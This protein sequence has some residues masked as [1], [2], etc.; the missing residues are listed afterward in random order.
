MAKIKII[1][2]SAS[3]ILLSE[4]KEWDIEVL[5]FT[6]VIDGTEYRSGIDITPSEFIAKLKKCKELPT[7]AQVTP[8]AFMQAFKK[9]TDEGYE[10][11]Y[12][13]LSSN[14]SGTYNN[15]MIAKQTIEDE[16]PNAVVEVIDTGKFAYIYARA[17][18]IA[19][20]M[21]KEGKEMGEIKQ[22]VLDFMAQ[23]EVYVAAQSLKYLEKGGRI[24]KASLVMGNVLDIR[25]ML[26]I[27]NGLIESI[28]TLRGSKK[29]VNKLFKKIVEAAP[30]QDGKEL[31][32]VHCDMEEEAK[33]MENLLLSEYPGASTLIRE[34]GPTIATHIGP[35]I[36]V[37]FV[38]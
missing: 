9:Y 1:T 34:V 14:A 25:P 7:T 26:S 12:I 2:D 29:I 17:S 37:F 23:Y 20:Q 19:A 5:P 31:I 24:N 10:V 35:V 30:P 22:A 4:A 6:V 18:I 21:A 8:D 15:A 11:L 32:I 13:S 27:R 3:D 16:D 28:G 36:A 33:E 38:L